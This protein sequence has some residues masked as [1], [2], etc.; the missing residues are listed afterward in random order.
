MRKQRHILFGVIALG[1]TLGASV[2]AQGDAHDQ[3]EAFMKS[4]GARLG[5]M[6]EM[7]QG[8]QPYDAEKAKTASAELLA[9]TQQDWRPLFPEGSDADTLGRGDALPNIWESLD[10]FFAHQTK[11][12]GAAEK[13]AASAGEGLDGLKANLGGVAGSCGGCHE[14][15]RK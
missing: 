13:L 9:L 4:M 7:V 10:D 2:R 14:T 15:Y 5:P 1:L 6:V 3:R 12:Q 8:K 11:L